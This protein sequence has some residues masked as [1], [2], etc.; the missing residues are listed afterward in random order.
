MKLLPKNPYGIS[1]VFIEFYSGM[2]RVIW[3][4]VLKPTL[5][6][7]TNDMIFILDNNPV[8]KISDKCFSNN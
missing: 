7:H 6:K 5:L 8:K 1:K 2:W 4:K 3:I